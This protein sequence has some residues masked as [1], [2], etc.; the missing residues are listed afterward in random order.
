MI[1]RSKEKKPNLQ[2]KKLTESQS[3]LLLNN[4]ISPFSYYRMIY[5]ENGK[6]VDYVFLAVNKA[7]EKETGLKRRQL[8]GKRV[9]EVYPSTEQY[10]IEVFGEIG[11]TR[12]P[13]RLNNYSSAF[14]KWY[15]ISAYSPKKGHWRL[16]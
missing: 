4:M 5:D 11:K 12:I 13:Q 1:S 2:G 7:F 3:R 16:Q 9:L 6:A 10:W 15:E 8:I 14:N